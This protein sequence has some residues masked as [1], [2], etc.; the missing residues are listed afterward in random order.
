VSENDLI[1]HIFTLRDGWQ[2]G[3]WIFKCLQ[4]SSLV[5]MTFKTSQTLV[6]EGGVGV[7]R[8]VVATDNWGV[9]PII[10]VMVDTPIPRFCCLFYEVRKRELNRRLIYECQCDERLKAFYG[11]TDMCLLWRDKAR[12]KEQTYIWV[13]VRWKI[14]SHRMHWVVWRTG[15]LNNRDE[16]NWREVCECDGWVCETIG[17]PSIF[18]LI[19]KVADLVRINPLWFW[20]VRRTSRGGRGR[21]HW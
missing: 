17:T 11:R 12:A 21:V 4:D 14:K 19:R 13:S 15:T 8:Q 6:Y 2:K 20:D 5:V 3:R 16:V 18:K 1:L 9:S 10:S 7:V